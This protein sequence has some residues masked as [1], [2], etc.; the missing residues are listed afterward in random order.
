MHLEAV[1]AAAAAKKHILL[2]KP[3]ATRGL[4]Q[5]TGCPPHPMYP[6]TKLLWLRGHQPDLWGSTLRWGRSRW[7]IPSLRAQ[8]F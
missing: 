7:T 4:Y 3:I 5:R 1:L 8:A 2:E 6:L